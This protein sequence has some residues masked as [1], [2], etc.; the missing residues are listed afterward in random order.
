MRLLAWRS[1]SCITLISTPAALSWV[2]KVCRKVCQPM[3]LV[4]PAAT[5]AG[6]MPRCRIMSGEY[7]CL[8]FIRG[9][10]KTQSSTSE[11]A[12][13]RTQAQ[14]RRSVII[15]GIIGQP[16]TRFAA[17]AVWERLCCRRICSAR[18][19]FARIL[20][21]CR[22]RSYQWYCSEPRSAFNRTVVLR[23][24]SFSQKICST[25]RRGTTLREELPMFARILTLSDC[26]LIHSETSPDPA[27]TVPTNLS[28]SRIL[29]LDPV[30][31][32]LLYFGAFAFFLLSHS[33]L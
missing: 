23:C 29:V 14:P 32:R 5:A 24:R 17:W 13:V 8:P 2:E 20:P 16:L 30:L 28:R 15:S 4:M 3:C 10:P 7:G 25:L 19:Q 6:R 1:N 31:S 9:L 21:S 33:H 27:V 26:S 18:R 11:M 12:T 22:R